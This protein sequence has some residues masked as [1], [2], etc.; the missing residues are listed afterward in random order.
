VVNALNQRTEYTYNEM[1]S[2]MTVKDGRNINQVSHTIYNAFEQV[3]ERYT[4]LGIGAERY[5]YEPETGNLKTKRDYKLK[6]TTY[7]YDPLMSRQFR[8]TDDELYL[9]GDRPTADDD[10]RHGRDD[11]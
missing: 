8:R 4:T 10:R 1:R 2:L 3:L 7:N 5:T 6:V 11:V 9:H